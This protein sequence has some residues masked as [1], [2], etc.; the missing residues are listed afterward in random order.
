MKHP[1][2]TAPILNGVTSKALVTPVTLR[3]EVLIIDYSGYSG[4][5][6]YAKLDEYI[7]GDKTPHID[8]V[9]FRVTNGTAIDSQ[10][11]ANVY[12]CLQYDIPY[13]VYGTQYP[14]ANSGSNK[15]QGQA[16]LDFVVEYIGAYPPLGVYGDEEVNPDKLSIALYRQG[17]QKYFDTAT[18]APINIVDAYTSAG[19]W[20]AWF[21]NATNGTTDFPKTHRLWAASWYGSKPTIPYDW[22]HRYTYGV[23]QWEL[24]QYDNRGRFDGINA[25]VDLNTFNG[26]REAFRVFF[27]LDGPLPPPPPVVFEPHKV[28]VNTT[29]VNIRAEPSATSEDIGTLRIDSDLIAVSESDDKLWLRVQGGWVHRAELDE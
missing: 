5:V 14:R 28:V 26:T 1:T 23:Y 6:D 12:G 10:A 22:A 13:G 4:L 11:I 9:I 3:G 17:V 20:D 24:W 19:K 7:H 18:V 27:D 2:S 15:A 25:S 16:L 29:A 8:G 21:A